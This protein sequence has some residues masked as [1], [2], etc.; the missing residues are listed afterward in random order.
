MNDFHDH[1][2]VNWRKLLLPAGRI[3]CAASTGYSPPQQRG[4]LADLGD[5]TS[6]V[7]GMPQ[8]DRAKRTL[9]AR[10]LMRRG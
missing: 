3:P 10:R 2:I 7:I 1:W 5:P 9:P 4:C 6:S 8:P